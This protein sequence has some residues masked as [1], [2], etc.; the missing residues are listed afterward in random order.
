MMSGFPQNSPWGVSLT[1]NS[2]AGG[3]S[4]PWQAIP[5]RQPFPHPNPA[6]G[7]FSVPHGRLCMSRCRCMYSRL[8]CSNG[9][10]RFEKQLGTN[11]LVSATYLGN[12]TTHLWFGR[13]INPA[14]YVPGNC[15]AGQYG[16]TAPGA[17]STLGNVNQR[18]MFYLA[19]PAQG[20][21]L[22]TISMLDDGGDADYNGLLLAVHHRFSNAF[23]ALA[24]YT[25]SHCL[26]NADQSN[27]GGI[28]NRYQN[29]NNRKADTGIVPPTAGRSLDA[30]MVVQSPRFGSQALRRVAGNWEAAGILTASTGAP[31][32]VTGRIGQ[33]TRRRGR[34]AGSAESYWQPLRN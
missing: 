13:E 9:T 23:T 3:F 16:L 15:V 30:S 1:L 4:D 17:C 18:R 8:M 10:W 34:G 12:K 20:Q 11:W 25:W 28:L 6:S 22:G 21:L 26:G 2:P 14:P 32:T 31:L 19:N 29:P 5:G 27:G 24:N 7:E 33:C